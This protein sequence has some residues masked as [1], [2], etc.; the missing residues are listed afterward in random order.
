[1]P[2]DYV[3][4][5]TIPGYFEAFAETRRLHDHLEKRTPYAFATVLNPMQSEIR[6]HGNENWGRSYLAHVAEM[7]YRSGL[8]WRWF[9]DRHL[10][11]LPDRLAGPLIVPDAHCLTQDQ[12]DA[13]HQVVARGEGVL[14]IGGVATEPWP[15]SGPAPIPSRFQAATF[16]LNLDD[17]H[18]LVKNITRPVMLETRV[19]WS[20]FEGKTVGRVDGQPG[21]VLNDQNNQRE[22]WLSGLPMHTYVRP[23][24]HSQRR[25]PTGGVELWQR[26]LIW[27][28]QRQPLV[29]LDPYPP[30]NDYGRTR[31]W[32][33]R[34][35]PTM[36]LL[37]LHSD[38]SV[39]AI[40]FPYAPVGFNAS[41]L[42]TPRKGTYVKHIKEIWK[43][44]DLDP[45]YL[46][47]PLKQVRIPLRVPANCE[48]LA[49][50]IE[51]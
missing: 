44:E 9:H 37:P 6:G 33:A 12:I 18:P 42:I 31:P 35:V 13:I 20:E 14:W 27:L 15:G 43:G 25:I 4:M 32:D 36:E 1:M 48:L 47:N 49:I 24:D 5:K 51:F 21:L 7:M 40:I 22:A 3:S 39:L 10:E 38:N 19:D 28:A 45:Q 26:L 8:S 29:Q 2:F 30:P 34:D 23:A 46:H 16:E 11:T 50:L 41:L 17:N